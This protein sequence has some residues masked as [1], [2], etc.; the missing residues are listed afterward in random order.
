[1]LE[2]LAAIIG[3]CYI[4][5]HVVNKGIIYFVYFLWVTVFLEV[6]IS[7][8]PFLLLELGIFDDRYM[9]LKKS[10]LLKG[11]IW[12]YNIYCVFSDLLYTYVFLSYIVNNTNRLI[13]KALMLLHAISYCCFFIFS[14]GFFDS[15]YTIPYFLGVLN[16]IVAFGIYLNEILRI[17]K[18]I[19]SVYLPVFIGF[20]IITFSVVMGPFFTFFYKTIN[21][22]VHFFY[23]LLLLISNA[24]LYGLITIGFLIEMNMDRWIVKHKIIYRVE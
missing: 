2:L 15:F 3:T 20:G 1:M 7:N 6:F 21:Y 23:G 4:K 19:S 9:L 12:I 22:K 8:I 14:E 10:V 18:S 13:V 5:K 17:D 16:I 11:N 24:F